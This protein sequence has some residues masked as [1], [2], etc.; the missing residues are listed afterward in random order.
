[1]TIEELRSEYSRLI[2]S[3]LIEESVEF[4]DIT[5]SCLVDV[6]KNNHKDKLPSQYLADSKMILQMVM[7]KQ[8]HLRKILLEGAS[9]TDSDGKTIF[10][11]L[12]DPTVING[13]VRNLYEMVCMYHII[14]ERPKS[15]DSKTIMYGLWTIAGLKFRQRFKDVARSP[16]NR[17]KVKEEADKVDQFIEVIK[18][19]ELYQNMDE[20]N[21]GKVDRLLQIKDYKCVIAEDGQVS[22]I[23]WQD[24]G[25]LITEGSSMFEN[26]YTY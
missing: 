24:I 18:A 3:N 15:D 6:L 5:I 17:E 13:M 21:K 10:D 20:K 9:F 23:S 2:M 16:E 11:G 7:S 14:Y 26:I 12:I 22:L 25:N 19:T 1:M 8:L 4:L